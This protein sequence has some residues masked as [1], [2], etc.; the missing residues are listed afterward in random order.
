MILELTLD[1][2]KGAERFSTLDN[3]I[4]LR[5]G[6]ALAYSL[7]ATIRQNGKAF[8][9]DGMK[10]RFYA[11]REDGKV[12]IDGANVEILSSAESKVLYSIPAQLTASIGDIPVAYFRVTTEDGEWA[13]STP[14]IAIKVIRGVAYDPDT[15]D[16]IPELDKL[17]A[18]LEEQR[19]KYATAEDERG[20]E[21]LDLRSDIELARA[22]A[23]E[24]ADNADEAR[25]ALIATE[26]AHKLA[27]LQR[28]RNESARQLLYARMLKFLNEHEEEH[29]LVR[30]ALNALGRL[31]PEHNY[32]F[33][34]H[35]FQ[36]NDDQIEVTDDTITFRHAT[37]EGTILKLPEEIYGLEA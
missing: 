26:N 15:G 18:Q 36:V 10:V 24:A 21:W 9:L 4:V 29:R 27:E 31:H 32:M 23:N 22:R 20:I 6:D 11:Q 33:L 7:L 13:A 37:L 14:N 2:A 8:E 1:I 35:T 3:P 16:Y 25:E 19:V 28:Q 5:Q 30:M 34:D 12:I 17:L